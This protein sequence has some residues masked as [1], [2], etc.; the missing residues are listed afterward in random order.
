[1]TPSSIVM[2]T[3]R[4]TFAEQRKMAERAIAQVTDAQ[5]FERQE[6][7]ANSIAALMKHVGGNLN[8]RWR[9]FLDSDGEK[10]DRN[11]DG[12]FEPDTDTPASIRAV[13]DRGWTTLEGTL[14]SLDDSHLGRTITIR[15]EPL[16][17]SLAL[18][19][20]LAHTAQHVGQIVLLARI[21]KGADWQ[22]LSIPR[23]ES[24][25]FNEKLQKEHGP[26]T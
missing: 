5:L 16:S 24:N 21:M 12:E 22:T 10:A 25:A 13:W 6:A 4:K 11:R 26:R 23:G 3:A 2:E 14:A 9:D 15:T 8:S 20:S 18:H 7:D 1:M 19:R 17:V